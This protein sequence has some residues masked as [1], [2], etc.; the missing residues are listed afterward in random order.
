MKTGSWAVI[1]GAAS[2]IGRATAFRLHREGCAVILVDIDRD[3]VVETASNLDA[4]GPSTH[5]HVADL[6][7]PAAVD[8]LAEAVR[9]VTD[10][11][12]VLVNAHGVPSVGVVSDVSVNEW[13]RVISTNLTAFFLVTKALLPLIARQPGASIVNVA[14]IAALVAMGENVAYSASKGGVVAFTRELALDLARQGVRVNAV[15]PGP[16]N[17]PLLDTILR[18]RGLDRVVGA[19]RIPL[20]R[21]GEP[22]EVAAAIHFLAS[23]D[24]SF[25][26]GHALVVDGGYS[27]W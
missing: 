14:S 22:S 5:L 20:R 21:F 18:E 26:T 10:K 6:S 24:S 7:D 8:D 13:D 2:G 27:I 15:C 9:G 12:N 1:T 25:V 17:T 16:T 3:G 19:K 4:S 23:E 11:L